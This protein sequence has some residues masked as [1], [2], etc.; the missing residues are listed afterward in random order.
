MSCTQVLE[1]VP[2]PL[3]SARSLGKVLPHGHATANGHR[4]VHPSTGNH[5]PSRSL[6]R[7]HSNY[8]IRD[9]T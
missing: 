5:I 8:P 9:V 1:E 4:L 2:C 3:Q 6:Y 7:T